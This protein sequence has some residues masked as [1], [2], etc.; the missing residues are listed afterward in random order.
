[1][2]ARAVAMATSTALLLA[3]GTAAAG[4]VG[5]AGDTL[6]YDAKPGEFNELNVMLQGGEFTIQD[7]T[8][9]TRDTL[10]VTARPPCRH[11]DTPQ[12]SPGLMDAYCPPQGVERIAID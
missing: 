4:T 9:G 10:F 12:P 3:T 8:S 2:R 1:M 6:R 5:I 7:G 11:D